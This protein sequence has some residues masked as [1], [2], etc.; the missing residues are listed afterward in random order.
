M[1]SGKR[2]FD[3]HAILTILGV[4]IGVA[5]LVVAMSAFSGF[6]T[7][8]KSALIEVTGDASILKRGGKINNLEELEE[9]LAP[10]QKDVIEQ[11]QFLTQESLISH[12][13]KIAMALL[14]GVEKNKVDR[15]LNI[16]NRIVE[17]EPSW[18]YKEDLPPAFMGKELAENLGL[19]VGD[20]FR[21]ILPRPSS[22]NAAVFSPT[23]HKFYVGGTMDFGKYD[24]NSRFLFIDLPLAQEIVGTTQISGIRFKLKNSEI[25]EVWAEQV[26]EKIGWSY[27][28]RDW[29]LMNKNFIT[30]I[31]YEKAVIFF[32]VLIIII[33]A[34]FNVANTLFV[35]VLKKYRDISLLK[36]LGASR[37]DILV[38]FCL[39]GL[40]LGFIGLVLG[41]TLGISLCWGFEFAQRV[42][43]ILPSD[44]YKLSFI[45]T[46]VRW[47]DVGMI[48][49]ATLSI[50]FLSTLVP[51]LRGAALK[52]VE[53]LKYE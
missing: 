27:A 33:A 9:Q 31:E 11:V 26:Q 46:E 19:K 24:Y 37:F 41:F 15:I 39:H 5:V 6:M 7:G 4:A 12:K 22:T 42:Y 21:I 34:C 18:D 1:T 50:C 25:A 48:S 53:G 13:G 20:V 8:L 28:V 43:P 49:I 51:A 10:Y 17:G 35:A 23:V 40:V 38:I 47:Q 14:Q 29:R 36:T 44:I 30:A 32:V 52:P 2:F 45:V 3:L 16:Q